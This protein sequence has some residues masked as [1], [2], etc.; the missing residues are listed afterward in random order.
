ML[1]EYGIKATDPEYDDRFLY[2]RAWLGKV[3][4]VAE[5]NAQAVARVLFGAMPMPNPSQSV[6]PKPATQLTLDKAKAGDQIRDKSGKVWNV[7]D[8]SRFFTE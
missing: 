6:A 2:V 3:E 8:A 5:R 4:F 7:V 1:S